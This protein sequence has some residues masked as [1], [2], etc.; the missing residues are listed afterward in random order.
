MIRLGFP[1]SPAP[2]TG[3]SAASSRTTSAASRWRTACGSDVL[4]AY[5]MN[6]APLPP[7]HGFPLR[8]VVPGWYGMA[9]VKWLTGISVV[10]EPFDGFQMRAYRLRQ[11][12][13]EEGRRR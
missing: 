9:H 4:L 13:D 1:E 3:S 5:E 12:P 2:T 6:D 7:Q 11:Q 8:L 10:A